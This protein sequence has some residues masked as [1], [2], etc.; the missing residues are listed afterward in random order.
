MSVKVQW[1]RDLFII[2]MPVFAVV[3]LILFFPP[4]SAGETVL[5]AEGHSYD[6]Y[7]SG[8]YIV[9]TDFKDDPYGNHPEW[10]RYGIIRGKPPLRLLSR[11]NIYLYN[12]SSDE[13]IPVYKS[14]C[15]SSFPWI[16]NGIVLWYEDRVSPAYYDPGDPNPYELLLYSVP[17][18]RISNETADNYSLLNPD[19]TSAWE[20]SYNYR[21]IRRP[22]FS[23]NMTEVVH[24][25]TGTSDLYMYCT[26]PDSGNKFLIASGPYVDYASPQ[27]FGERIFWEDSRSGYSQIY[28]YDLKNGEEYHI[29]PQN[30]AQYDCSVDGDIVAWTTF[31]GDL[32]FTDISGL[33]EPNLSGNM[34]D[35]ESAGYDSPDAGKKAE[36][37]MEFIVFISLPLAV[38]LVQ[39]IQRG[40]K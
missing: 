37:G 22:D 30:F 6:P 40:S 5:F 12:I 38:F 14:V 18:G 19:V 31:G 21:K 29:C 24:G 2:L 10:K 16:E 3:I 26:D 17:L 8:N 7:V 9:Y 27:I 36:S 4:V 32:Y 28:M 33:T 23:S 35:N 15:R 34:T 20:F 1:K 39:R 25:D 11:G 13:T